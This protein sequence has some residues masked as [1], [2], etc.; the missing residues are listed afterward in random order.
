MNIRCGYSQP[1][2]RLAEDGE[3]VGKLRY[4]HG[5]HGKHWGVLDSALR[6]IGATWGEA[7]FGK[8][9]RHE[10]RAGAAHGLAR[11]PVAA[12]SAFGRTAARGISAGRRYLRRAE[13]D[14][15]PHRTGG[16][17]QP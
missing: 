13:L 4:H 17:D 15:A 11:M 14:A 12:V 3:V 7:M 5:C 16:N 8:R 1:Y 6:C 2:R 10:K 9:S